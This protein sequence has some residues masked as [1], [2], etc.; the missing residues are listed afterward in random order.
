MFGRTKPGDHKYHKAPETLPGFPDFVKVR[1]KTPVQG[2]GGIRDRWRK[3]KGI[4]LEWDF[5]HGTVEKYSKSGEHRGE[6][7]SNTEKQLNPAIAG[8]NIK[9][10]L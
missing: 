1:G 5:Q 7:N 8:R 9:R 6:F 4:I 3:K 10:Y 2:G